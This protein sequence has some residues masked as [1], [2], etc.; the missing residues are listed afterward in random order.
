[1]ALV[2]AGEGG[3]PPEQ[4]TDMALDR[5]SAE[6]RLI[7]W[8]DQTWPQDIGALGLLDGHGL[9]DATGHLRI[10]R[11]RALVDGRLDRLPRLRQILHEPPRRQGGPLWV[12]APAFDLADHVRVAE[13]AAPGHERQLLETVEALRRQRLDPS[14]PLWEMWLLTGL[15]ER[16]IGLFVRLHHVVADG[17]AGIASLT[18]FLDPAPDTAPTA[19]RPWTPTPPPSAS[20]LF[21]DHLRRQIDSAAH[22]LS[23]L[24]RPAAGLRR[25]RAAWPA[26]RELVTEAP[27]PHTS[28]DRVTGAERTLALVR[29]RLD[30]VKG[31]AHAHDA[32]VNDVLLAGIAGGLRALLDSRGEPVEALRLPVFVPVSLR[33]DRSGQEGGN[34]ISQM[35][36]H[37]PLGCAEPGQRLR[38]IS[39]ETARGKAMAH[40]SLGAMF[41]N[42]MISGPM[43]KLFVRQRVN[44]VSADLPGPSESL[45]LAGA[46]LREL[47]PLLNLVGN[48]TMGVGALS[49]AGQF[50]IMTVADTHTCPDIEVFSAGIEAELQALG[51]ATRAVEA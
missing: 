4:V 3:D 23:T 33:R 14:R 37:L 13:V 2:R 36:V 25:A 32:T 51:A 46:Q 12:D 39:Q 31:V 50:N 24:A 10:G 42:R 34:L 40:P 9:L 43:L 11:V 5:L 48:Q 26:L 15:P 28:L 47:F 6:D 17:I 38:E 7:L 45:F 30:L 44:I 27:G 21:A 16:R 1:V 22:G 29:S 8:P 41:G 49:Y 20:E 18:A 35:V 19:V